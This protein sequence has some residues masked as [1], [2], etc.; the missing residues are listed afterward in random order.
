MSF[1]LHWLSQ[2]WNKKSF[3]S[4]EFEGVNKLFDLFEVLSYWPYFVNYVLEAQNFPSDLLFNQLVWPNVNP[5]AVYFS[6][7][8]F[9]DE[10]TDYLLWGLSPCDVVFNGFEHV[11]DVG[12]CLY[13]NCSVYLSKAEFV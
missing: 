2:S 13:E 7:S 10:F 8:L 1:F 6:V 11:Q 9:I 3:G 4:C 5:F 12:A